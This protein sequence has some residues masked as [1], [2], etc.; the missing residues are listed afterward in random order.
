MV[1]LHIKIIF[2]AL[3]VREGRRIANNK[4]ESIGRYF[5][6]PVHY[7]AVDKIVAVVFKQL[8]ILHIA[9]CPVK[10]CFRQID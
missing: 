4:V 9:L 1:A 6:Y 2:H 8:V 5:M 7:I 10:I 3:A